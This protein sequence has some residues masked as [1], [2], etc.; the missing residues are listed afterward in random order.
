[1]YLVF[2]CIMRGSIVSWVFDGGF[3]LNLRFYCIMRGYFVSL[4]FDGG[5][6]L[7]LGFYC[8]MG[9]TLYLGC[10]MG[11]FYCILGVCWYFGF[12]VGFGC[13]GYVVSRGFSWV[14]HVGYLS[15]SCVYFLCT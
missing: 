6:L 1:L 12:H 4:V 10:L 14:F 9:V 11:G 5:L 13:C 3:L 2:Y 15:C 8:I 7:Y